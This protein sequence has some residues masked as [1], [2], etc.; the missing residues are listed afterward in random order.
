MCLLHSGLFVHGG[1]LRG[2]GGVPAAVG[3]WAA[4]VVAKVTG[5][6]ARRSQGPQQTAA[7]SFCAAVPA[8]SGR[9]QP[10]QWHRPQEQNFHLMDYHLAIFITVMLARRLVWTIVS[11]VNTHTHTHRRVSVVSDLLVM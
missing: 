9:R 4:P 8:D 10:R 5:D 11:E 1:S 6:D 7:K 2:R 3:W